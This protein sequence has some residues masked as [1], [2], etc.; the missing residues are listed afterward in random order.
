VIECINSLTLYYHF[1]NVVVVATE[2]PINWCYNLSNAFYQVKIAGCH[3]MLLKTM[4]HF[5]NIKNVVF[6]ERNILVDSLSDL[7]GPNDLILFPDFESFMPL[8]LTKID[9]KD[10]PVAINHRYPEHPDDYVIPWVNINNEQQF[11]D[12]VSPVKLKQ[13]I[14]QDRFMFGHGYC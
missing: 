1:D 6:Y 11:K 14:K 7:I 10:H 13:F 12:A 4:E 2:L 8:R 5:Y 3:P 9:L